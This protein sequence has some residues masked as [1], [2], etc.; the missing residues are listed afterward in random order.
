[1]DNTN[2]NRSWNRTL[3][4]IILIIIA[5]ILLIAVV[6][7]ANSLRRPVVKESERRS[8]TFIGDFEG[9]QE[10]PPVP[11]NNSTGTGNITAILS[12]DEK[13]LTFSASV[14]NLTG[15]IAAAHFH[16]G[17]EGIAGPIVK[18]ITNDFIGD[19]FNDEAVANGLWRSTDS[20]P[21]TSLL[22][23]KLKDG[24]LYVNIH[25]ALFPAGEVRAQ[26]FLDK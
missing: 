4:I 12:K 7:S 5:I 6:F 19:G 14:K 8:L 2:Q 24:D 3:I 13:M 21:L 25:T 15:P 17:S 11:N 18:T 22:V 1:M 23:E 9:E 26:L 20:Q 10:V 16:M